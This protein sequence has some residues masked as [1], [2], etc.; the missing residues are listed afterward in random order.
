MWSESYSSRDANKHGKVFSGG[1][2]PNLFSL[3]LSSALCLKLMIKKHA[4]FCV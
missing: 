4:V 2:L 3:E 1:F